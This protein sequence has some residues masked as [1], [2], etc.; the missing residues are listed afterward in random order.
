MYQNPNTNNSQS[1]LI[2]RQENNKESYPINSIHQNQQL[3]TTNNFSVSKLHQGSLKTQSQTNQNRNAKT[4]ESSP[5]VYNIPALNKKTE[6]SNK[7]INSRTNTKI[8]FSKHTTEDEID[9]ELKRSKRKR[10]RKEK[11]KEKEKEKYKRKRKDQDQRK[12]WK[13][14]KRTKFKERGRSKIKGRRKGKER[15]RVGVGGKPRHRSNTGHK[16]TTFK[17]DHPTKAYHTQKNIRYPKCTHQFRCRKCNSPGVLPV[18]RTISPIG[19]RILFN[20]SD[21]DED[22]TVDGYSYDPNSTRVVSVPFSHGYLCIGCLEKIGYSFLETIIYKLHLKLQI[23]YAPEVEHPNYE[24]LLKFAQKYHDVKL[25]KEETNNSFKQTK[26][27]TNLIVD[28]PS[29]KL[30]KK[31][32]EMKIEDLRTKTDLTKGKEN[33][34]EKGNGNTIENYNLQEINQNNNKIPVENRIHQNLSNYQEEKES[35]SQLNNYY[36]P[37]DQKKSP[38]I[39][40]QFPNNTF[41]HTNNQYQ[42]QNK[43]HYNYQNKFQSQYQNQNENEN[44]YNYQNEN[45]NYN[46]NKNYYENLQQKS[47]IQQMIQNYSPLIEKFYSASKQP[48]LDS[49]LIKHHNNTQ[50]NQDQ[51]QNY[52][53]QRYNR[54][55]LSEYKYQ[56]ELFKNKSNN[57]QEDKNNNI[58]NYSN[59]QNKFIQKQGKQDQLIDS[60]SAFPQNLITDKSQNIYLTEEQQ[61]IMKKKQKR[62]KII[63]LLKKIKSQSQNNYILSQKLQKIKH[64][65]KLNIGSDN[66][67]TDEYFQQPAPQKKSQ[68]SIEDLVLN[69]EYL[70]NALKNIGKVEMDTIQN[71]QNQMKSLIGSTSQELATVINQWNI[72]R[73][74]IEEKMINFLFLDIPYENIDSKKRIN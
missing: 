27:K 37:I 1:N 26:L 59:P 51:N 13:K 5:D 10:K 28:E 31:Q 11:G 46:Q 25:L 7:S 9:N 68:T 50:N 54:V 52:Y 45:K 43:D 49:I 4:T 12:K 67:N 2:I 36:L 20:N 19:T 14:E 74:E 15:G 40:N 64:H 62:E 8:N 16:G 73:Y 3:P 57:E 70:C 60:N 21:S 24:K 58:N 42:D 34:N 44:Y 61:A 65:Q 56:H 6:L 69:R 38:L 72:K 53:H 47:N 32:N 48:I 63:E 39:N 30:D 18:I 66:I 71:A 17:N 23:S 55:R 29:E 22:S 33:A 35:Q 41:E